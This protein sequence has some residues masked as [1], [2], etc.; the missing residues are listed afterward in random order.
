MTFLGE[1]YKRGTI[2]SSTIINISNLLFMFDSSRGREYYP[3][4]FDITA[5]RGYKYFNFYVYL[6]N[7][8][9]KVMDKIYGEIS[10]DIG[11]IRDPVTYPIYTTIVKNTLIYKKTQPYNCTVNP[12]LPSGLLLSKLDGSISGTPKVAQAMTEYTVSCMSLTGKVEGKINIAVT[13]IYNYIF[14]IL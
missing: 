8:N 1:T 12:T 7:P 3:I 6:S 9:D 5:P 11:Y 4:S 14:I 10:E 2:G 13:S